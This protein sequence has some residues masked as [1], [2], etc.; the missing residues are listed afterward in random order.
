[1]NRIAGYCTGN[2]VLAGQYSTA[3]NIAVGVYFTAD[4]WTSAKAKTTRQGLDD[5]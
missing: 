3:K 1:M 4:T 5:Q 2:R